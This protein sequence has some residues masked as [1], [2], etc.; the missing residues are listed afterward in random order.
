MTWTPYANDLVALVKALELKK[1]IH[2]GHSTGGDEVEIVQGTSPA[3]EERIAAPSR[4]EAVVTGSRHACLMAYRYRRI[5]DADLPAFIRPGGHRA[6]TT[7]HGG[8][9][10]PACGERQADPVRDIGDGRP[11]QYLS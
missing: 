9:L 1:A 7:A 8:G 2:V 10:R 6:L 5:L 4:E 11:R 3:G